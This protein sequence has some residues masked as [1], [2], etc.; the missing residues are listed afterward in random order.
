[1]QR[2]QTVLCRGIQQLAASTA[3]ASVRLGHQRNAFKGTYDFAQLVAHSKPLLPHVIPASKSAG[4]RDTIDFSD[5]LSVLALNRALLAKDYGVAHWDIPD[6]ALCPPVPSRAD[7]V[8]HVGDVLARSR[9]RD[10]SRGGSGT[11]PSPPVGAAVRGFD[12]GAGA[13]LVYP[14]IGHG[15]YGWSFIA[16]ETDGGSYRHAAGLA[17]ANNLGADVAVRHQL[18]PDAIFDGVLLEGET[19]DFTMCNPPF[20]ESMNAFR[21]ANARKRSLL[22]KSSRKRNKRSPSYVEQPKACSSSNGSNNFGGTDSELW[23]PGGEVEFI[24]KIISASESIQ[25]NSLWFSSLL[26]RKTKL[27]VIERRL[28]RMKNV[29]DTK[30][31]ST[32]RGQKTSTLLFWSFHSLS[33]Q[34]AWAERRGWS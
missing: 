28:K 17:R 16:S 33:E 1:M 24:N 12:V 11:V 14:L 32:G 21:A 6:G 20:Y 22:A 5:P 15:S 26:S 7:Y 25:H 10:G 4:G 34:A 23:C 8:H 19:V 3:S 2:P 27:P 30:I 18:S 9:S 29:K 31:I 13:S